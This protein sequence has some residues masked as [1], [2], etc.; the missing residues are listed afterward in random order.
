RAIDDDQLGAVGHVDAQVAAHDM[1]VAQLDAGRQRYDAVRPNHDLLGIRLYGERR[2][3]DFDDQR[4]GV[5]GAI[6]IGERVGEAVANVLDALVGLIDIV[7]L[8]IDAELAELAHDAELAPG[9]AR[10]FA[11]LAGN[12]GDMAVRGGVGPGRTGLGSLAR[13]QIASRSAL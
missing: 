2:L 11:A 8:G 4:C 10:V 5:A 13:D 9:E 1:D 3:A 6:I 7:A 12:G